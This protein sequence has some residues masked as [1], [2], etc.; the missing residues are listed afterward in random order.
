ML[1]QVKVVEFLQD[2]V[3]AELMS[4]GLLSKPVAGVVK[5]FDRLAH[6]RGLGFIGKQLNLDSEFHGLYYRLNASIGQG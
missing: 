5:T 6:L 2:N 1:S 3:V 4:E